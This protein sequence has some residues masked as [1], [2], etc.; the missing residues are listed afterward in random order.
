MT[1]PRA[2]SLHV[3]NWTLVVCPDTELAVLAAVAQLEYVPEDTARSLPQVG[4][5]SFGVAMP[6]ISN[7]YFGEVVGGI[8]DEAAAHGFTILLADTHARTTDEIRAVAD[9]L[10]RRRPGHGRSGTSKRP[11]AP[12][13]ADFLRSNHRDEA[14]ERTSSVAEAR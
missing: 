1:E 9:S 10:E 11:S 7:V 3:I 2:L 5:R 14:G 8:E 4:A 13:S 12:R 6:T